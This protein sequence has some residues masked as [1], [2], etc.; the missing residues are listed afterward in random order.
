MGYS[1]LAG[2]RDISHFS[3]AEISDDDVNSFL[4]DADLGVLRLA[5]I[6]VFN[7]KMAGAIDGVNV[8][9]TTKHKLIADIDFD[10]DVDADDVTVYLVDYDSQQ[11]QES[12]S[13]TVTSVNARDGIITLTTAPTISNAE[14]GV[15]VDYRYYK[16]PVDYDLLKLAAN[17]FLAHKC[18]MKIR[19]ERMEHYPISKELEPSS[20]QSRWLTLAQATLTFS[21]A[22]LKV[23]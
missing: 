20:R 18:E 5:T 9:F 12:S 13:T 19:T 10:S 2:L 3:T 7:E 11:N 22:G 16:T 8:L 4:S 17:Y 15:Y 6:E 21:K 1:T 23:T 14:V